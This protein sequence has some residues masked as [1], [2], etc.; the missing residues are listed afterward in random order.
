VKKL[1]ASVSIF[2]FACLIMLF[3]SGVNSLAMAEDFP[4]LTAEQAIAAAGRNA[5]SGSSFTILWK[6]IANA[7]TRRIGDQALKQAQAHK[8]E[9]YEN[10]ILVNIL[11]EGGYLLAETSPGTNNMVATHLVLMEAGGDV[12][13]IRKE[14]HGVVK[15]TDAEE[16]VNDTAEL[17]K[18]MYSTSST[19]VSSL[20]SRFYGGSFPDG[21]QFPDDLFAIPTFLRKPGANSNEVREASALFWGYLFWP[22]RYALSMPT[23]AAN[24]AVAESAAEKRRDTLKAEFLQSNNMDPNINLVDFDN[25]QNERQLQKR[26]ELL[27]RL[28][29]FLEDALK[30]EA[31]PAAVRQN[32]SILMMPLRVDVYLN[33]EGQYVST[34]P[35]KSLFLWHRQ[36]TGGFAVKEITWDW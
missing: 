8:I 24:S 30:K 27:T 10:G 2:T 16:L 33:H 35:P 28:N 31:D 21:D 7:E 17:V 1:D 32:L 9:I 18:Q 11:R 15:L 14:C 25:I 4:H 5:S 19:E 20:A 23:F 6:I 36:T 3:M 29:R 13:D 12:K 22:V 34:S 26:I